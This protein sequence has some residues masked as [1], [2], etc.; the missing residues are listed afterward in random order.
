MGFWPA[1][2]SEASAW[3]T[4][5]VCAGEAKR[6]V[7]AGGYLWPSG[8]GLP[9]WDLGGALGFPGH[10]PAW[11]SL[12]C[13]TCVCPMHVGSGFPEGKP[14]HVLWARD[15]LCFPACTSEHLWFK[16]G[17]TLGFLCPPVVPFGSDRAEPRTSQTL[18]P[19]AGDSGQC[20]MGPH[21]RKGDLG[22]GHR[23]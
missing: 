7:Q 21:Q 6:L 19:G 18:T 22:W 23:F 3:A 8:P 15:L 5:H 2:Q 1:Q 13:I 9:L 16:T 12:S 10:L 17:F 20:G 11:K 14:S 4:R